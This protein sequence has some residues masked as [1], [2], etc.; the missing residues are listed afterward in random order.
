[1]FPNSIPSKLRL[2]FELASYDLTIQ[3]VNHDAA[4]NSSQVEQ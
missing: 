3:F 4:D 2:E 1:M